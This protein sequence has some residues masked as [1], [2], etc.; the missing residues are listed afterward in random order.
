MYA[1]MPWLHVSCSTW[2][3]KCIFSRIPY[4]N[5]SNSQDQRAA[6]ASVYVP[7]FPLAM[8]DL[9]CLVYRPQINLTEQNGPTSSAAQLWRCTDTNAAPSRVFIM[10]DLFVKFFHQILAA[11]PYY[12]D[13]MTAHLHSNVFDSILTFWT[14]FNTSIRY[15]L[16]YTYATWWKS[17]ICSVINKLKWY[18]WVQYKQ[19]FSFKK[20]VNKKI[21]ENHT[22]L[23]FPPKNVNISQ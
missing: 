2:Y 4:R 20:K 16:K 18:A 5:S 22:C 19:M 15:N 13:W 1:G 7:E 14:Q 23:E 21:F 12:K 17:T 9:C 11:V 6:E 3:G 8:I 10:N